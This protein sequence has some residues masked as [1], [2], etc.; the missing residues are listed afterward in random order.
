MLS[1]CWA[2]LGWAG[3]GWAGLGWA[4]AGLGEVTVC[5]TAG[6][7]GTTLGPGAFTRRCVLKLSSN[8]KPMV[9]TLV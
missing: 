1:P 8:L 3:L 2:G 7:V 4:G 5:V 9:D 6:L